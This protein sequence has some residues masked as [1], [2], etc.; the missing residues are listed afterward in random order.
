MSSDEERRK[1][2]KPLMYSSS[3]RAKSLKTWQEAQRHFEL[4]SD[5]IGVVGLR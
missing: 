5:I 3:G 1:S 2:T 4:G